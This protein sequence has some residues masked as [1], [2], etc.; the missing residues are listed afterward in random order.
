MPLASRWHDCEILDRDDTVLATSRGRAW[1]L[2]RSDAT[3]AG[4]RY[5]SSG[6]VDIGANDA[7][8]NHQN[9]ILRMDGTDFRV[10]DATPNPIL[11]Y[12]DLALVRVQADG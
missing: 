8:V 5:D 1:R 9:R 7:L 10:I 2:G 4:Q 3:A 11:G 12:I 6:V